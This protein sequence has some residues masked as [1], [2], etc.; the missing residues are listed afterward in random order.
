[1][2]YAMLTFFT[3]A[4]LVLRHAHTQVIGVIWRVE[5]RTP[6]NARAAVTWT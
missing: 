3:V 4:T 5:A 6:V 1:M 2:Y